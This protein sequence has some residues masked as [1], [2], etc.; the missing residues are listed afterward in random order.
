MPLR[1]LTSEP[2]ADKFARQTTRTLDGLETIS[3]ESI[4]AWVE[5]TGYVP[6]RQLTVP[7]S[8]VLAARLIQDSSGQVLPS[9]RTLTPAAAEVLVTSP[10]T[11]YLGL[12]MRDDPAV[13]RTLT[14]SQKGVKLPRLRAATPQV[15]DILKAAKS[16]ETPAL[17][18]LY[19]LPETAGP[20]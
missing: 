2:L 20:T 14:K 15:I 17:G 7:D 5:Y 10:N 12:T 19:I 11:I 8:P 6:L 1:E 16:I 18:S 13:A 9:L 3:A 4:P